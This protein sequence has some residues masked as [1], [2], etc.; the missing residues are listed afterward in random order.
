MIPENR[1]SFGKNIE[2]QIGQESGTNVECSQQQNEPAQKGA[3]RKVEKS[4][5]IVLDFQSLQ[6]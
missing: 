1:P 4:I 3:N 2:N 6:I 5:L